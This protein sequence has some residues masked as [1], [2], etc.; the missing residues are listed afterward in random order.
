LDLPFEPLVEHDCDD[1]V[2][3]FEV[4]DDA[5]RVMEVLGKRMGRYG[6]TLHPDKTV[7]AGPRGYHYHRI[8]EDPGTR[9]FDVQDCTR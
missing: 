1:F 2:M 6:L 4:Q 8:T 9:G 5:E 7:A 3:T